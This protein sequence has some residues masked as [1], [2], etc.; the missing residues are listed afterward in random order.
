MLCRLF[1]RL[2][3]GLLIGLPSFHDTAA[4]EIL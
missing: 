4:G 3:T 1:I 2:F